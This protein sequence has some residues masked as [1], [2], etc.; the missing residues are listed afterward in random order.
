MPALLSGEL[1]DTAALLS[2]L[3]ELLER[4]FGK[5]LRK[6]LWNTWGSLFGMLPKGG[7]HVW[8]VGADLCR[9]GEIVSG[10]TCINRTEVPQEHVSVAAPMV[11]WNESSNECPSHTTFSPSGDSSTRAGGSKDLPAVPASEEESLDQPPSSVA[12]SPDETIDYI[13]K[14]GG[15]YGPMLSSS[16]LFSFDNRMAP[17]AKERTMA[18]PNRDTIAKGA[19][20]MKMY[21]MY[22]TGIATERAY[23]YKSSCDKADSSDENIS[24]CDVI[25]H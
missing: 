3:G 21:C 4:Y 15:G 10:L 8:G 12:W 25:S 6:N 7:D 16:R 17:Q 11:Y 22:G 24:T 5:R 13:L 1:K 2:Q 9:E 14:Y 23:F 19:I 18:Q 20:S